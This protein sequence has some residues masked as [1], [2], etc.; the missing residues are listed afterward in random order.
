[1]NNENF[2][3]DIVSTKE[4]AEIFTLLL[5]IEEWWSGFFGESING[6]SEKINDEYT[7]HA[8]NGVHYSKQRLIELVPNERIVWL[9]T[10]SNLTFLTDTNEWTGTKIRFDINKDEGPLTKVRFTH[11]GLVPSIQC[12]ADCSAGWTNYLDK[13]KEKLR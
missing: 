13:L 1:M 8:G 6:K 7:Y 12:Y 10:E 3:Y 2:T 4:P 5:N 11:E 9:V